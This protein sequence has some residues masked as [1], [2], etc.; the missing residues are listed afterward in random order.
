[1]EGTGETGQPLSRSTGDTMLPGPS[2]G[3]FKVHSA[4]VD[5]QPTLSAAVSRSL[6]SGQ[7]LQSRRLQ[8]PAGQALRKEARP[9]KTGP[10]HR[11]PAS[12][13]ER[14]V[15]Q[16]GGLG[17]VLW[18][19]HRTPVNKAPRLR[20]AAA[21]GPQPHIHAWPDGHVQQVGAP[22]G[23]PRVSVR[24]VPRCPVSPA[25]GPPGR[26]D[27][28]MVQFRSRGLGGQQVPLL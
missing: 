23:T 9:Q 26:T 15:S 11:T 1:M 17:H 27:P 10:M 19:Y 12:V 5:T 24:R 7:R 6:Q 14:A 8:S 18:Y 20:H 2:N 25:G 3:N 16:T 21:S 13:R 28:S 4:R 22:A